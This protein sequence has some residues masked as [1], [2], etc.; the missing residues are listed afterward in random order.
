MDKKRIPTFCAMCGPIAGC[1]IYAIVKDGKFVAVE[2]MPESPQQGWLCPKAYAAPQWVYSPQRLKHPLKRIGQRGEGKFQEITWDE[3]LDIIAEKLTSQKEKFGPESL[4]ILSP[5]GRTIKDYLFRFLIAHGSPNYGHSGICTKQREFA[6]N[7]TIGSMPVADLERS[8]LILI[9]G[10]QPAFS[11]APF[12][13]LKAILDAQARGAKVISIKPSL[14]PDGAL[15]DIWMPIR[16][17]TDAALALAMLNIIINEE[18]YDVDFVSRWTYGFEQ[19]EEHIQQYP[20]EWAASITGLTVE[21][22]QRVSRIYATTKPAC[23]FNGNGLEHAPSCSDAVRAIAILMA[24]TG[25]LDR[26]GGDIFPVGSTMPSPNNV[27][28]RERYTQ[29]WVDK[30]VGPEFPK[31]F[32]PFT[33]GT[34]SAYYRLFESVLTGKPYPIKTL[35]AA[36]T[37]PTVS[38]RGSKLVVEALEKVD[39]FFVMDVSRTAEMDYAD[40]VIP[41]RSMYECDHPFEA[42]GGW[43]MAR[44]QVIEPLG[45]YKSDYEFWLDLGTRMGYGS[46]FWDGDIKACQNFQLEPFGMT[47]DEL[48]QH[49]TGIFYDQK[50]KV[51]E[52]Y[53]QTFNRTSPNI[54]K[55]PYLPQGKVAIY[56]TAFEEH[57]FSPMPVWKEPPESPTA[58]PELLEKY[59]LILTD[60]H[61]SKV[62]NASWLRNI[63]LLREI[64]PHPTLQINP[65][66][67]EEQEIEDGD[68]V[69]VES[70]HGTMKMRAEI[71]PGIRPDT[72]MALHGWWQG[73]EE[74]GLPGYPL[75]DGGANT[76]NLYS[77]DPDKAYDPLVTAMSSQTLV[78]IR[79][80]E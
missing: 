29:E 31:P 43:I 26:P 72:V 58:T 36:G 30:L 68:W 33:E 51:Y 54:L 3:A 62:F 73:C 28:L 27:H 25:N 34:T 65:N 70:P 60:Y 22:I 79:K 21:Q 63:P 77:V 64:L 41:V 39:F 23:I 8:N 4:G 7:Y 15:A 78:Q 55:D 44:N 12:G 80:E 46:D 5:A 10:K 20:P 2:G 61:T 56:N 32:Q 50:P 67:A 53:Q 11:G 14:E 49:P 75:L 9:W 45:D 16:P 74:L 52:K 59:P 40:V 35:V 1:G 69:V 76:N 17:G 48:R 66:T 18:L 19:L 38:T 37:Q 71:Y 24:I 47:S 6:F 57:G 13:Q 42:R